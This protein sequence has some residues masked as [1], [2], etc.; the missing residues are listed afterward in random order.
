[1]SLTLW[2]G[3]QDGV[4]GTPGGGVGRASIEIHACEIQVMHIMRYWSS[5]S[6]NTQLTSTLKTM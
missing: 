2:Q 4:S 6:K 3:R 1:M 5:E